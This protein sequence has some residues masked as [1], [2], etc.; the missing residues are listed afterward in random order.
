MIKVSTLKKNPNNPRI[1]RDDKFEKLKRSIEEF[2][3]MM[4]LRPTVIDERGI[5]LGGNM[6]FEAIKALGMKEVPDDWVKR[7]DE[8]TDEQK[9]EFVVKDNV[10]FGEWSWEELA[11]EW[12]DLPLSDWGLD[13]PDFEAVE[14][15]L[16]EDESAVAETIS[17]AKE[18][19]E[20]WGTE[21]GQLW[22]LGGHRLLCG[23]STQE[24]DVL[25]LMGKDKAVLMW[26]DPP[27]G[28]S[29]KGKTKDALE[30]ENDDA[31]G[32]ESL[33]N[34][35]FALADKVLAPGAAIYIA[36]PAGALSVT[37][38]VCFIAAGWR[39]HQTLIWVKDSMVLGHSDYHFKHEPIKFGYKHGTG[40]RGRGGEGWYS[41]H[42]QTS[43][44]MFDRPKR[45][46]EH[47][48]MKPVALVEYCVGNSSP[49]GGIVYEPFAGSGTTL[50]ACESLNR[51]CY[52]IEISPEY[53]AICLE[54]YFLLT[55]KTPELIDE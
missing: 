7:A 18:L 19:Q 27:Y 11:N 44:L 2:P 23:S 10:G 34:S 39:L 35:S 15:P 54:R 14:T 12:S 28:V 1:L 31:E 51:K 38:G 36:H 52:A 49:K 24:A 25:R 40:R 16:E 8:L 13:V 55:G 4:A 21:A 46:E 43:V 47:P 26:T 32:L 5:I 3:Q 9:R 33:L 17:K 41:D 20:K 29:Y 53:T 50:I 48:T 42:S 6:R 30:I 37:F 45:S 22:K